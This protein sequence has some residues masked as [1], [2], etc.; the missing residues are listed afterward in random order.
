MASPVE[1]ASACFTATYGSAPEAVVTAPGRVNLIG[2]HTDYVGGWVFPAPLALHTAIAY[3]RRDDDRVNAV[4]ANM[5][6]RQSFRIGGQGVA[7][8]AGYLAACAWALREEGFELSGCDL[9]VASNV[10]TGS[11]LSSSAALEVA[12]CR[13]FRQMNALSLSDVDIAQI[14]KRAENDYIGVPTGILDQFASSVPQGSEAM[15]LDCRDLSFEVV[16][17]PEDWCFMVIDSKAPRE[18]ANSAYRERVSECERIAERLGFAEGLLGLRELQEGQ[19]EQLDGVLLRRARH[20]VSENARVLAAKDAML[21]GDRE[22]FA[23]AM[24]ASHRSL[25]DDYEVS[26]PALDGIVESLLSAPGCYGARMT[27]GGFG[28]CVV[29]LCDK[30]AEQ[31]LEALVQRN[32]PQALHVTSL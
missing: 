1:T 13:L 19:L 2:E 27:G 22:G 24:V 30:G 23:R 15:L 12:C 4:S 16:D 17:I 14:G 31:E 25:R 7:P 32:R 10:P 28:G 11:S 8:W 6:E 9:A 20:I 5:S 21:Q 18:L 3:R 29:A 26:S